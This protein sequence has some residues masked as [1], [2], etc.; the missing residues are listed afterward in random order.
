SRQDRSVDAREAALM[1]EVVDRLFDLAAHAHDRALLLRAQPQVTMIEQE[2]DTVLLRL[3]RVLLARPDDLETLERQLVTARCARVSADAAGH[4]N[5]RLLGQRL[6]VGPDLLADL[7]LND[8]ALH[9]A[10]AV[11]HDDE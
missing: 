4:V 9:D 5:A 1:E 7:F 2:V 3:D 6:K 8:D 10:G 11:A